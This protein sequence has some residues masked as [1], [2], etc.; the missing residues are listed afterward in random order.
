MDMTY[1]ARGIGL[2]ETAKNIAKYLQSEEVVQKVEE[3]MP[4]PYKDVETQVTNI[5]NWLCGLGKRKNM[6]LGPEVS[7]IEAMSKHCNSDWEMIVALPCDMDDEA[8]ARVKNNLPRGVP[9]ST[10]DEPFFP[11]SFYPANGVIIACGYLKG[12]KA[13]VL[14]ETY[15]MI[16][17]YS[18]FKGK[19]VFVPYVEVECSG[20]YDGW[21]EVSH[22]RFTEEWRNA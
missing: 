1:T 2:F 17:H 9:V 14:P 5:A 12:D 19:V 10:L 13:M 16:E 11:P 8:K 6:F 7:L 20:S 21:M 22:Q 15:R 18:L 4:L 3:S